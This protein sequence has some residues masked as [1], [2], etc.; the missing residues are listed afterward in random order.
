GSLLV[1]P[2]LAQ[3]DGD[4]D[5]AG[6]D[7]PP[8]EVKQPRT[9]GGGF[10]YGGRALGPAPL[11]VLP[12]DPA[13]PVPAPPENANLPEEVDVSPPWQENMVCDPFDK[14]GLEAFGN[15]VGVHFGRPG[16]TTSRSCI[17]L[18]SE[19]YDGRAID[20]QLNAHD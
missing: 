16:Y 4:T 17:D 9:S 3:D 13:Y 8:P 2:A 15:L 11:E 18:K 14:P 1:A 6:Q 7:A 10:G 12:P 5:S 20:W 19:H